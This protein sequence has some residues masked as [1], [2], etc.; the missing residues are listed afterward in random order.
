MKV[1][2]LQMPIALALSAGI[3]SFAAWSAQAIRLADGT[4]YFAN[5]PR[6]MGAVTTQKDANSWGAR[7]DFT[8]AM[9]ENAGESLQKVAIAQQ[10]GTAR[11]RFDLNRTEAFEG[12][13][14]RPA[15][16]LSLKEVT[17]DP[18]TLG[19]KVI[20]D[21]PVPPGKTVTIRLY[22]TR[23][24]HVGGVYLYGVTAFPTGEKPH[25]QF[26]G[27]GRI[28]IYEGNNDGA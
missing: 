9:P 14:N 18:Q 10:Q 8:L 5:P 16:R 24:P 22:A 13:P 20:F 27:F 15:A 4:T 7:Y 12:T 6:L 2:R 1:H 26:L 17:I 19:I 21:P 25:G 3:F 28:Q 23:N 11:P